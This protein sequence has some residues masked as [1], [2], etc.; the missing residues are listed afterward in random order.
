MQTIEITDKLYKE[1]IAQRKGGESISKVIERNWRSN[2]SEYTLQST[3]NKS[4]ALQEINEIR[5][6]KFYTRTQVEKML[7]D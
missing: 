4:E 6:G 1:I 2:E 7:K 5:K 3:D